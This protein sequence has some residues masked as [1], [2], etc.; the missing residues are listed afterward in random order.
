MTRRAMQ[1][2]TKKNKAQ[3]KQTELSFPV[4]KDALAHPFPLI[5]L[6]HMPIYIS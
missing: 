6:Q 3:E 2:L 5:G 4:G 1:E